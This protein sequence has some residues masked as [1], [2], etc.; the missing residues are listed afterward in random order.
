LTITTHVNGAFDV[1]D[2][3][4]ILYID[5]K[6]TGTS[7]IEKTGNGTLG[8]GVSASGISTALN[9]FSGGF[10]L[11]AGTAGLF[12]D[13]V[14]SPISSSPVG[15]GA[16]TIAGGNI[17]ASAADRSIA[18]SCTIAGD[19]SIGSS[20]NLSLSGSIA[21]GS[22]TRTVTVNN[23]TTFSGVVSGSGALSK[24]GSGTRSSSMA[25]ILSA[26]RR[27]FPPVS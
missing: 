6:V 21:L 2:V 8:L 26:V 5:A 19:F 18:N 1:E 23:V 24:A 17:E 7:Q 11:S 25:Q 10:K 3:G 16:F 22:A 9:T 20:H 13:S 4:S 12:S 14:G 15:T 27:Q